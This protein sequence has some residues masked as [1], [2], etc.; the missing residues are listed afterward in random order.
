MAIATLTFDLSVP[1][2]AARFELY[3]QAEKLYW[4]VWELTNQDLRQIDKYD[5][6]EG[7]PHSALEFLTDVDGKPITLQTTADKID[8]GSMVS[9]IRGVIHE[10]L[11][12]AN[13]SLELL[14]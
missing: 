10:K 1:E 11:N 6:L 13:V 9:I 14:N 12:G 2:D 4:A 8:G 5:S 7:V 3:S